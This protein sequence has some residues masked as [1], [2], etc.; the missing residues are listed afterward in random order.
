MGLS[1]HAHTT[2]L[3][4][5]AGINRIPNVLNKNIASLYNRIFKIST[6]LQ[7]LTT[8]FLS[9]YIIRN[10]VV[11]G[12]FID[13][14]LCLGLSPTSSIFNV[15]KQILCTNQV[16]GDNGRVDSIRSRIYHDNFIK[17]YS[18]EHNLV[19]LLTK[20][21]WLYLWFKLVLK[22]ILYYDPTHPMLCL[23]SYIFIQSF[24]LYL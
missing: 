17:P 5:S 3:L 6:P 13:N 10:M 14:L 2:E 9:Q 21:F 18:E 15:D 16:T 23:W 8:Y 24:W 12:T 20:S 7:Y 1:K 11:S 4:L 22:C 19:S